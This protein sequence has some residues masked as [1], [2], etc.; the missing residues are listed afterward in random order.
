MALVYKSTGVE[1]LDDYFSGATTPLKQAFK[2][3]LALMTSNPDSLK[4]TVAPF[5]GKEL[6]DGTADGFES[7]W[8]AA[9]AGPLAGQDVERV[10]RHGY[11]QA[12]K[13]ARDPLKPIET[14]FV[15][16]AGP[17]FELHICEG[18]YAVTVFMLIPQ[19]RT[20]G[21]HNAQSKSWVVRVGH[22]GDSTTAEELDLE[23]PPTVKTLVSG[24]P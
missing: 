12:I 18:K 16:G 5:E 24:K 3:G 14:F 20:H 1:F 17:D 8:L 21:S 22:L 19:D 15:T 11:E 9:T 23:D 7:G 13:L 6:P 2:E 10:M 4:G